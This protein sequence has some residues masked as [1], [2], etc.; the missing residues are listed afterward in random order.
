MLPT[1]FFPITYNRLDWIDPTDTLSLDAADLRYNRKYGINYASDLYVSGNLYIGGSLLDLSV[2]SGITPGNAL[3][4]KAL[5][6]DYNKDISGIRNLIAT[7]LTGTLLTN[8]QSNITSVGTLT[9]LSISNNSNSDLLTIAN[10]DPS[11]R[12]ALLILN[13]NRTLEIGLRGG[14]NSPNDAFY[15]YDRKPSTGG[16]RLLIQPNGNVGL[17]GVTSTSFQLDTGASGTGIRA[18]SFTGTILTGNQPNI[19]SV[20]AL[21]I[22][23]ANR[24]ISTYTITNCIWASNSDRYFGMRQ[25]DTNNF[26]LLA[27]SA[28]GSYNDY[29]SWNYSTLNLS[30]N[31]NLVATNL[32][33]TLLTNAQPNITSIGTLTNLTVTSTLTLNSVNV[34]N[35]I[36]ILTG[37]TLGAPS[38]NKALTLD[39]SGNINGGF[40]ISS[41]VIGTG[42]TGPNMLKFYGTTADIGG[43]HTVIAERIYSSSEKSEL[44]LFK[45]ND[46]DAVSGPDRIR[47]RAAEHR[48]QTFTSSEDWSTIA[49]NNDRFV[50]LN[51]GNCGISVSNPAYQLELSAGGTGINTSALKFDG[52]TFNQNYYLNITTGSGDAL[53]AIVPNSDK[54]VSGLR[55]LNIAGNF[56]ASSSIASPSI[57]T[58][59]LIASVGVTTA[60]LTVSGNWVA[61]GSQI[62]NNAR[63]MQN[64][65]YL[66]FSNTSLIY[67]TI[68]QRNTVAGAGIELLDSQFTG[69]G[70]ILNFKTTNSADPTFLRLCSYL[71]DNDGSGAFLANGHPA[72]INFKSGTS[73]LS[74]LRIGCINQ[75][76]A[77]V[78]NANTGIYARNFTIPHFVACD[79]FNQAMIKPNSTVLSTQVTGFG[80][81]CGE[82]VCMAGGGVNELRGN[83]TVLNLKNSTGATTDRISYT[84]EH[85]T[86][87]EMSLGGSSHGSVPNGLYWYNSGYRMVLRDSGRL[88]IGTTSPSCALDVAAGENSV[89]TTSN[90][91]IDT[92]VYNISSNAWSNLGG[93]PVSVNMCARFRGSIWVQDKLYATSDRRLKKDITPLDFDLDHYSKLNPVSYTWKNGKRS[94]LGLIAQEVKDICSEAVSLVEND[95]MK[96]EMNGDIEKMQYCIDYN[97]INIMSIVVIKKLIKN[98]ASIA[99]R[100]AILEDIVLKKKKI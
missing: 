91:M 59:S 31:G 88:G 68:I 43:T 7:N 64:I 47:M 2:I 72:T 67:K 28:G 9:A 6:I 58:D 55:N 13:D 69:N 66:D 75:S 39:A 99:D 79:Q 21:T 40:N 96:I 89:T 41:L 30:I 19:T 85:N 35:T 70:S 62:L 74:G 45:G 83:N 14:S 56:I 94:Q 46:F 77:T 44:I 20:G 5:V 61:N 57:T 34:G 12:P 86:I 22:T 24:S 76:Q 37:I 98:V 93:G 65:A 1:T 26:V 42:L 82:N 38:N 78:N 52:V 17:S 73:W 18:S 36:S 80:I 4:S 100:I 3:A 51:N 71:N 63:Q 33:G 84:M 49:D 95:N 92:L 81:I 16:Y 87:W 11:S 54:D 97:C 15:I 10:T 60:A 23:P 90:F 48:F 27:H 32:T 53:K 29:I 50:I 25:I 8:S